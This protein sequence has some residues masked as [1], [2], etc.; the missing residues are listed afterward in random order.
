MNKDTKY[1][2]GTYFYL[3]LYRADWVHKSAIIL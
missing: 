2:F 1:T 3:Y